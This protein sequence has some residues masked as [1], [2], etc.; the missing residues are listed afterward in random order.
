MTPIPSAATGYF[1]VVLPQKGF[2]QCFYLMPIADD[3]AASL[4]ARLRE[5][6][7]PGFA[8][9]ETIIRWPSPEVA[10]A[11]QK[12]FGGILNTLCELAETGDL[13]RLSALAPIAAKLSNCNY[14][15]IDG[16]MDEGGTVAIFNKSRFETIEQAKREMP[17]EIL[18][19]LA[20]FS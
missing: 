19:H 11:D 10:K 3:F 17:A 7:A 9:G 18:R 15:W 4:L 5:V 13:G 14:F 2:W 16:R 6:T 20:Q 8:V 1:G 12:L